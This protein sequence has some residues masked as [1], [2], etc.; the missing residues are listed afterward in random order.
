MKSW[1]IIRIIIFNII[2]AVLIFLGQRLIYQ[3]QIIP[4]QK[5]SVDAWLGHDYTT[6]ALTIFIV[7]ISA[8]IIWCA[9]AATTR[10][11]DGRSTGTWTLIWW[12]LGLLP[13]LSIGVTVF[14]IN[15]SEEAQFS[16]M[17]FFLLDA[18]LLYWLTTVTSS[19]EAVKYIP[20]GAFFVRH[21]LMG[22]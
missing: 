16:L 15:K 1:E 18:L 6:A 12:L 11:T 2:G 10:F 13:L 9:L 5:I 22:D 21:K 3:N 19:P 8:T 7:C 17:V 20:P 14:F 4:I